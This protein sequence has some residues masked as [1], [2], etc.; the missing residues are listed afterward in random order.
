MMEEVLKYFTLGCAVVP[1][2]A[3]EKK[4]LVEWQRWQ[5]NKQTKEE[6]EK[7]PWNEANGYALVCGLK[8]NNGFYLGVLDFDVKNLPEDIIEKGTNT[9]RKFPITQMEQTPSGGQHLIYYCREKPKTISAYHNDIALELIGENKLVVMAPSE[10]YKRLNDN[11]PTEISDLTEIFENTLQI[12]GIDIKG[13]E[14]VWFGREDLEEKPYKGKNPPCIETIS[15]GTIEGLRNEFGIRYASYLANFRNLQPKT[16]NKILETWNELNKPPLAEPE[17]KTLLSSA[18]QNNYIYGCSDPIFWKSCNPDKCSISPRNKVKFLKKEEKQRAEE[19][20]YSSSILDDVLDIGQNRL[21]GEN[22]VLLTNFVVLCSGQTHYPISEIVEGFSGSGKNESIRAV[23][24]LIPE[25]WLF[26]FTTSTPEAVKYIPETFN[27][28]LVIYEAAGMRS[29]TSTLGLRAIGEGESIETIYPM[30]NEATGQMELG[31]A[32]TNAKN[33]VTTESNV[34]IHPDLYRRVLQQSMNHSDLLTKRVIAKELREAQYPDSLKAFLNQTKTNNPINP[35]DFQNAMRLNEWTREVVVFSPFGLIDLIK[36]AS[37]K[38]QRVA[39]RTHVKKIQNFIRILALTYQKRRM[40]FEIG[41]SKYVLANP[42]DVWRS[43]EILHETLLST[44]TR[45]GE[46][47]R[48]VLEQFEKQNPL[49]KHE[50]AKELNMSEASA[51]KILK[52]LYNNGYLREEQTVK[53]YNYHLLNKPKSLGVLQ[54]P[55]EYY[56]FFQTNLKSL[57][58]RLST[59]TLPEVPN[60]KKSMVKIEG[61]EFALKSPIPERERVEVPTDKDLSSFGEIKQNAFG[62]AKTPSENNPKYPQDATTCFLCLKALSEG[63]VDTTYVDGREVHIPC[64]RRLENGRREGG[65]NPNLSYAKDLKEE[66]SESV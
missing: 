39:V 61:E 10:G 9:L 63:H 33:F 64:L 18:L 57:L 16:V 55:N 3:K 1:F 23:K 49:T 40:R 47:Q 25:E 20:L 32:K 8:L 60:L 51:A 6:F 19:I 56:L 7:M 54:D 2:N 58:T 29:E 17:L 26:E 22:N 41:E 14:N 37:T 36:L 53:P 62:L 43:L 5:T 27:G 45:L 35:K 65:F 50:V 21:I 34:E 48:Q 46:R 59:L 12:V 13:K 4:P 42:E 24:P 28:S 11:S 15:R 66:G 30:R 44:I 52:A 31:R 38:E